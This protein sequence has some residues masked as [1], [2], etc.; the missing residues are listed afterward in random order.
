MQSTVP[1][2][3]HGW[4]AA[5][6]QHV[7]HYLP[8]PTLAPKRSRRF[9]RAAWTSSR[10]NLLTGE[11]PD[12]FPS[13]RGARTCCMNSHVRYSSNSA[14]WPSR[15]DDQ[16]SRPH[17]TGIARNQSLSAR[18]SYRRYFTVTKLSNWMPKYSSSAATL[19]ISR[20]GEDC[21]RHRAADSVYWGL[22]G[23]IAGSCASLL[24][25][26]ATPQFGRT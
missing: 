17:S 4:Y 9:E 25:S 18:I 22:G 21:R 26:L 12:R 15:Q 7:N 20:R 24:L 11:R 5:S 8:N 6:T 23:G 14:G 1:E 16:S 2:W 10:T 13:V 3:S 19:R